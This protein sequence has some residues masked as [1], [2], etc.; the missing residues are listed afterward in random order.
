M[1]DRSAEGG[2][3]VQGYRQEIGN[4]P[5]STALF[6]ASRAVL[7]LQPL[8]R[9]R[10]SSLTDKQARAA[11]LAIELSGLRAL[12]AAVV[13]DV[14][15]PYAPGVAVGISRDLQPAGLVRPDP[16]LNAGFELGQAVLML[17][18]YST[19][20]QQIS[21]AAQKAIEYAR[22]AAAGSELTQAAEDLDAALH[23]DLVVELPDAG[24]DSSHLPGITL[25]RPLWP[26]DTLSAAYV[27][28]ARAW[29]SSLVSLHL[30]AISDRYRR[31]VQGHGL[32][33]SEVED[34]LSDQRQRLRPQP[35]PIPNGRLH[36][37][38]RSARARAPG[39][40]IDAS[41]RRAMSHEPGGAAVRALKVFVSY[42]HQ[43]EKMRAKLGQHL[44]PMVDDGLIRIWHDREI[45]AGADWEREIDREIAEADIILL[46]VSSAFLSSR[47]CR[48]ELLQ[49]L[50]QRSAHKSLPIPI[51]LRPCEWTLVFN[52]GA[53]KPQAL[54]R[55]DRPVAGGSWPNQDTAFA[56]IARELRERVER[57]RS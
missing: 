37:V 8:F 32:R 43:D 3:M 56:E 2:A 31:L 15:D 39:G 18:P 26:G 25:A 47:Y 40:L 11:G 14:V 50:D 38:D 41:G 12:L 30:A 27:E 28:T 52:R 51:I 19:S 16:M 17:N 54:P 23:S 20:P 48:N 21:A 53:Y 34:W 22:D 44:A 9:V 42:S 6:A 4:L 1:M 46:L 29:E 33:A 5:P 7:R 10:G 35:P 55:N 13:D 24:T 36:D 45:G 57:M 49:A